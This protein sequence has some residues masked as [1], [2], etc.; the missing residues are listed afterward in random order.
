VSSDSI[1]TAPAPNARQAWVLAARPR[2]LP[3]SVGPVLVGTA[4]AYAGGGVRWLPA[5][6]ALAAALLLQIGS[7]LAN[8]L[9]DFEKGA[10]TERRLGPPRASQMGLLSSAQM[11]AGMCAVFGGACVVGAYLVWIGGWPIAVVGLVS[12]AAAVAYTGGPWPFG[13]RGLGDLAVFVFFGVIAVVGTAYLQLGVVSGAA[14]AASLPVGCLATAILVVNNIRDVETDAEAGKRTLAVRLGRSGA[15]WEYRLLL[16][17][18]FAALPL[19]AATGVSSLAVLAPILLLP[20]AL[21]LDRAVATRVDGP[22]LN[23]ALAG[24]ARL[25]FLFCLLFALGWIWSPT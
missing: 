7:N 17:G 4:V 9:F 8:D 3:V 14:L 19:Y 23:E 24:T 25:G 21:R 12:I 11:R 1:A 18:P 2:T 10:D 13:Y 5:L 15:V 20:L 6:A 16:F 22:A